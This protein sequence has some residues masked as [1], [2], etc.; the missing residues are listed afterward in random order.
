MCHEHASRCIIFFAPTGC[1]CVIAPD[2]PCLEY[3]AISELGQDCIQCKDGYA[4]D[5]DATPKVCQSKYN[6]HLISIEKD[7]ILTILQTFHNDI[8]HNYCL[9]KF[10][11]CLFA[12]EYS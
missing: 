9:I 4:L 10:P 6:N 2:D 5:D 3:G 1:M 12:A 11:L 7:W 8:R